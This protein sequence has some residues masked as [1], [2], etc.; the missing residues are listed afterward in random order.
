[1]NKPTRVDLLDTNHNLIFSVTVSQ[2]GSLNA[3]GSEKTRYLRIVGPP[4]CIATAFD[5]QHFRRGQNAVSIA[6]EGSA[7]LVVPIATN[8]VNGDQRNG[9][10]FG[11]GP[12]YIWM[13]MKAIHQSGWEGFLKD[14][15][16]AVQD[17]LK[18]DGNAVA[19]EVAGGVAAYFF[20]T[21]TSNNNHVDNLS[22]IALGMPLPQPS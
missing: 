22:S 18:A 5:D 16:Q 2:P 13:L 14:S 21:D 3:Q 11:S 15:V 17:W 12:G 9:V 4:G 20:G 7:D 8:F 6:K 10:Y 1:M 19:A